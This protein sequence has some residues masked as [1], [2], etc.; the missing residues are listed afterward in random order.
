M[1]RNKHKTTIDTYAETCTDTYAT[2]KTTTYTDTYTEQEPYTENSVIVYR[3][4]AWT[5]NGNF[6][7]KS[8]HTYNNTYKVA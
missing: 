8:T 5:D 2:T 3:H 4:I 6:Q 7:T 1:K